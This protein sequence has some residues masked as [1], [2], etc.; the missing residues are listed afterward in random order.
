MVCDGKLNKWRSDGWGR[1]RP[2]VGASRVGFFRRGA[3]DWCCLG[4][5]LG[6]QTRGGRLRGLWAAHLLWAHRAPARARGEEG[7]PPGRR[8]PPGDNSRP[9]GGLEAVDELRGWRGGGPF[10]PPRA[11]PSLTLLFPF[12]KRRWGRFFLQ[13]GLQITE[14]SAHCSLLKPPTPVVFQNPFTPVDP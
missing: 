11:P 12:H 13:D 3:W 2:W 9:A 1:P 7:C 6:T 8:P 5:D 10:P 4:T 14:A